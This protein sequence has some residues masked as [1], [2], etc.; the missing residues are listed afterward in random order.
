[1]Y[2][3]IM[4]T[5]VTE[6]VEESQLNSNNETETTQKETG[7][8]SLLTTYRKL[9]F[10]PSKEMTIRFE[11]NQLSHTVMD[12]HY[13]VQSEEFT[14]FFQNEF[15]LKD[16]YDSRINYLLNTE[17]WQIVESNET[18]EIEQNTTSKKDSSIN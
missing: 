16:D 9:P 7:R 13:D 10:M 6:F 14:L 5:K 4:F 15:A 18:V 8:Y 1:M 2:H 11:E 3:F 12:L 17:E